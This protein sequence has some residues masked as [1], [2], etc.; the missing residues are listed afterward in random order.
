MTADS[1]TLVSATTPAE[2]TEIL[3]DL[4]L[5]HAAGVEL[6]SKVVGE[7]PA[8]LSSQILGDAIRVLEREVETGDLPVS[9]HQQRLVAAEQLGRVGSDLADSSNSHRTKKYGATLR[10]VSTVVYT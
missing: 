3:Q 7:H 1:K 10:A 9:S 4:F 2:S 6:S 5:G 8:K